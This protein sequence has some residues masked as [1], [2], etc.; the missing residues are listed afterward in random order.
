MG[1]VFD[2]GYICGIAKRHDRIHIRGM[3]AHVADDHR[4]YRRQ[5]GGKIR[6]INPVVRPDFAQ[7]RRIIGVDHSGG[8]GSKGKAGDQHLGILRQIQRQQ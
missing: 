6:H 4:I 7:H 5:L 1:R 2:H 3:P 8:H